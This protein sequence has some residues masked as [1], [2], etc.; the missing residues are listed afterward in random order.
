MLYENNHCFS[1]HTAGIQELISTNVK[2]TFPS[3]SEHTVVPNLFIN[4]YKTKS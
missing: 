1:G 4:I 3:A 2:V